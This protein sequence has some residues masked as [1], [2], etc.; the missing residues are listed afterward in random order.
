MN[1]KRWEDNNAKGPLVTQVKWKMRKYMRMESWNKT[2]SRVICLVGWYL[3]DSNIMA[4]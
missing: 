4:I 2:L 1:R 3:E